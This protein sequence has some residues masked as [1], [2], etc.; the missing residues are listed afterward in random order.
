[1]AAKKKAK[2]PDI[3]ARLDDLE[4]RVNRLEHGQLPNKEELNARK[5]QKEG[6]D[7]N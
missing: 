2:E 4:A 5:K 7:D 3:A 1:M 6:D